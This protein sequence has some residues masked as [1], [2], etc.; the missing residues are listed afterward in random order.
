MA[1]KRDEEPPA[2][3]FG[4]SYG[5]TAP[6]GQ[7]AS[8]FMQMCSGLCVG[9]GRL[10]YNDTIPKPHPKDNRLYGGISGPVSQDERYLIGVSS[11]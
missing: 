1:R 3:S 10:Q 5:S 2:V 9:P 6:A 8:N 7:L 11:F 4:C